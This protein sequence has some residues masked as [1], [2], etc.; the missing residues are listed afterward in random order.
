MGSETKESKQSKLSEIFINK[1]NLKKDQYGKHPN[2][3]AEN[4]YKPQDIDNN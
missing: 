3:T 2:K 4:F 1:N